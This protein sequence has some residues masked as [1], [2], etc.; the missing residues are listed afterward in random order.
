MYICPNCHKVSEVPAAYC[1]ACGTAMV[2]QSAPAPQ[3]PAY[4]A[5]PTYSYPQPQQPAYQQPPQQYWQQPP[6]YQQPAAPVAPPQNAPSKGKVI[7]GMVLGIAG[8]A[9]ASLGLLYTFIFSEI[10]MGGFV[11]G[12]V[13]SMISTPLSLVGLI[14]S[15]GNIK[16]GDTSSMS[17]VGKKLGLIGVILSGVMLFIAFVSLGADASYYDSGYYY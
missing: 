2:A 6:A 3:A 7:V 13:F 14:M 8:L 12:L 9:M 10:A 16:A 4:A 1:A 15:N 5:Q 11:F 17:S